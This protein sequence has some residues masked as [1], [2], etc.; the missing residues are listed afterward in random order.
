MTEKIGRAEKDLLRDIY[1][2]WGKKPVSANMV[3]TGLGK[4]WS[5]AKKY[6]ENL[7]EA[8]YMVKERLCGGETDYYRISNPKGERSA[9]ARVHNDWFD[10]LSCDFLRFDPRS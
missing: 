9:L 7:F 2:R 3:S 4:A 5:Q 6:L 8:G 1:E 10:V